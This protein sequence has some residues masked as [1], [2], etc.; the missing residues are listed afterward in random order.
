M[1]NQEL[2]LETQLA[3]KLELYQ[4]IREDFYSAKHRIE[5]LGAWLFKL[6][7]ELGLLRYQIARQGQNEQLEVFDKDEYYEGELPS[8]PG[9]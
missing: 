9:I 3:A 4:A 6:S 5:Y 7:G 8:Q 1:V 2:S